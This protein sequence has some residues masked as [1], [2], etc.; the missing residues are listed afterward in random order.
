MKKKL[1][2]MAMVTALLV[3]QVV[4][5]SA[6]SKTSSL[7]PVG[8]SE[9]AYSITSADEKNMADLDDQVAESIEEMNAGEENVT[10]I[11][12][13][14]PELADA[15]SDQTM[16]TPIVNVTPVDG[17]LQ[18][19]NGKYVLQVSLPGLTS[20]VSDLRVVSY[21]TAQKAW[22]VLTPSAIDWNEKIVSVEAKDLSAASFMTVTAKTVGSSAEGES[23]GTS[24]VVGESP[25]TG[26]DSDW[27]LW[28]GAAG[29]LCVVSA[30]AFRKSEER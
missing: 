11:A 5:V 15:L 23:A 27:M 3:S 18:T 2:G 21:N 26:V 24:S 10:M 13:Q 1:F 12:Q 30:A 29:I 9:N 19:E 14:Q 17:G 8:K 28:L 20:N 22:E 16:L 4:C 6:K 25:K 7:W